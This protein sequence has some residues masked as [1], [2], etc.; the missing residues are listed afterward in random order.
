MDLEGV[1]D[2][3]VRLAQAPM[4]LDDKGNRRKMNAKELKDYKGPAGQPGYKGDLGDLKRDRTSRIDVRHRERCHAA[5]RVV[6][7]VRHNRHR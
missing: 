1:E 2:M 6:R 4:V 3:N 5:R 7:V